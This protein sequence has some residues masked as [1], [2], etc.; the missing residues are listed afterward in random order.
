MCMDMDVCIDTCIDICEDVCIDTCIDIC[1]DVCID[2]GFYKDGFLGL[3]D[4]EA[5]RGTGPG[6]LRK[7]QFDVERPLSGLQ[8]RFPAPSIFMAYIVMAYTVMAYTVMACI[9]MAF[10]SDR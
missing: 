5:Y 10:R 7:L 1:E 9:V 4:E 6:G 3:L 8:V 2:I